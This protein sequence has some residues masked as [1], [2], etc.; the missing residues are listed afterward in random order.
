MPTALL[1][2][3]KFDKD[4]IDAKRRLALQKYTAMPNFTPEE[5]GKAS[6]A[7]SVCIAPLCRWV[8]AVA[9]YAAGGADR[10]VQEAGLHRKLAY[11]KPLPPK[12]NLRKSLFKDA[13]KRGGQY[14]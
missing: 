1:Q 6:K 13:C 5:V 9:A 11:M 10:Q 4:K 14:T 12:R 7:A 2:L 8:R 3:R